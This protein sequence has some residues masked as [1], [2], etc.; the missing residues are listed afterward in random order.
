MVSTVKWDYQ[1]LLFDANSLNAFMAFL[2]LPV[3]TYTHQKQAWA[4]HSLQQN[5]VSLSV[6]RLVGDSYL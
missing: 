1:A 2:S 4:P 5:T 3:V 6:R